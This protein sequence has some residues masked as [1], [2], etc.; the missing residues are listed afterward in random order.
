[1]YICLLLQGHRNWMMCIRILCSFL[2]FRNKVCIGYSKAEVHFILINYIRFKTAVVWNVMIQHFGGTCYTFCHEDG[3]RRFHRN[4][5]NHVPGHTA[6]YP[7]IRRRARPRS[8]IVHI[9]YI[10]DVVVIHDR[11][12]VFVATWKLF[13]LMH[14]IGRDESTCTLIEVLCGYWIIGGVFPGGGQIQ[15]LLRT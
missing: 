11:L 3:G 2:F 1:M 4:I 6:S 7:R 8:R 5:G 12:L 13:L 10:N 14:V 15:L 9:C